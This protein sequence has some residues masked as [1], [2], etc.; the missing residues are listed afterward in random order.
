[1]IVSEA[2]REANRRNSARSTGPRS[3]EGKARVRANA[4]KHGMTAETVVDDFEAFRLRAADWHAALKPVDATQAWLADEVAR[5]TL[6]LDHA[7]LVGRALRDKVATRAEVCWD[8]DRRAEVEV[9]ARNLTDR[10]SEV[11]AALERTVQ[12]CE[13][14][15]DRWMLLADASAFRV[16]WDSDR[17]QIAFDLLGTPHELRGVNPCVRLDAN[18]RRTQPVLAPADF[19]RSEVARLRVIRDE[20]IEVDDVERA[21]TAADLSDASTPELRRFRR[22]E[23]SLQNRLKWCLM[24]FEAA[25]PEPRAVP[26]LVVSEPPANEGSAETAVEEPPARDRD[27]ASK[28]DLTDLPMVM[29]TRIDLKLDR[30]ASRREAKERKLERRRA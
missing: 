11:A 19:A 13:W 25:K 24:R 27:E 14:M 23:S 5:I 22:Y 4:I 7:S 28:A 20:L 21:M 12:G 17:V 10:P 30:A 2:R 1:M 8:G 6:K 15:I 26:R 18:S 3:P 29:P 16:P 9:L